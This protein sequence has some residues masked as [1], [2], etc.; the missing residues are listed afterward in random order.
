MAHAE[1]LGLFQSRCPH[2][3]LV[4]LPGFSSVGGVVKKVGWVLLVCHELLLTSQLVGSRLITTC[5]WPHMALHT[6]VLSPRNQEEI[7]V[8]DLI[9]SYTHL[10][11]CTSQFATAGSHSPIP[12]FDSAPKSLHK[13]PSSSQPCTQLHIPPLPKCS[14]VHFVPS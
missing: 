8:Q 2:S 11:D 12:N 3:S 7:H 6:L 10:S 14:E 5:F 1:N 9:I 13:L 4:G